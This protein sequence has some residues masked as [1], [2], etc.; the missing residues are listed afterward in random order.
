MI[1]RLP[2]NKTLCTKNDKQQQIL[3]KNSGWERN[4]ESQQD[5]DK[6]NRA[7]KRLHKRHTTRR[8]PE[9]PSQRMHAHKNLL[10]FYQRTIETNFGA[11]HFHRPLFGW[12][13]TM[14]LDKWNRTACS[15]I[16]HGSNH[17][18]HVW[19]RN[20]IRNRSTVTTIAVLTRNEAYNQC[21]VRL[22]RSLDRLSHFDINLHISSGKDLTIIELFTRNTRSEATQERKKLRTLRYLW[23]LNLFQA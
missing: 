4:E 20:Y 14:L 3:K 23:L 19:N 8:L 5:F 22:R 10:P 9:K 12:D 11:D 15:W 16:G 1:N 6:L 17:I 21:T 2:Q 13:S 18:S 7:W